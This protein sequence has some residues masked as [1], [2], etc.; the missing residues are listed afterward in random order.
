MD[1][2]GLNLSPKTKFH[3]KLETKSPWSLHNKNT[4]FS[5]T[6]PR[7]RFTQSAGVPAPRIT[8]SSGEVQMLGIQVLTSCHEQQNMYSE[9]YSFFKK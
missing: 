1:A 5:V 3:M 7:P 2:M 6:K 4:A 8:A 9:P